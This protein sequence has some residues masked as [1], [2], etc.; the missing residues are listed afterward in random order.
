[1]D[2]E[3]RKAIIDYFYPSEF[4]ELF[5]KEITM[6]DLTYLFEDIILENIDELKEEMTYNEKEESDQYDLFDLPL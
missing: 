1:M 3:F 6:E 5:S 4:V 2:K